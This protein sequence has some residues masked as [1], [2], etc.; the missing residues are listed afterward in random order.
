[1]D[2]PPLIP[3]PEILYLIFHNIVLTLC[4]L[5]KTLFLSFLNYKHILMLEF[6]F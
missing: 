2:L 5:S 3:V 6:I 1:M 4:G